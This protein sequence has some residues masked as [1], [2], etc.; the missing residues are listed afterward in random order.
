MTVATGY[1]GKRSFHGALAK[2]SP[3]VARPTMC[4]VCSRVY[5]NTIEIKDDICIT[6]YRIG[7]RPPR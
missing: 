3:Y 5:Q 6:C 1:L 7:W 4:V 2:H